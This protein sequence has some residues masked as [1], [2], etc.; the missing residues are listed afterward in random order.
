MHRVYF[1]G[2]EGTEDHLYGI[3]LPRSVADLARIPDGPEEGMP[4][5]IYSIG[6]IEMDATLV[7]NRAWNAWTARP[8]A[9]TSR[10]NAETWDEHT[11]A[12]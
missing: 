6:E 11:V 7:W 10:P 2:N 3:W 4:V 9:G 5:T 8:I 12:G 1:D